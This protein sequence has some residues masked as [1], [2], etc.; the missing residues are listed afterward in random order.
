MAKKLHY[1]SYSSDD[2]DDAAPASAHA[3]DAL[4]EAPKL[5]PGPDTY[6]RSE[7]KQFSKVADAIRNYDEAKGH[8]VA[9]CDFVDSEFSDGT[10]ILARARRSPT[11]WKQLRVD[12]ACQQAATILED[13]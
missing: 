9:T 1:P 12:K 3:D 4:D 13:R 11:N 10:G 6:S 2:S 5:A 8:T 7:V